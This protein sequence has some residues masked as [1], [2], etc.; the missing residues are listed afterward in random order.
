MI[1]FDKVRER[2]MVYVQTIRLNGILVF[3]FND[4]YSE[5]WVLLEG[6]RIFV[7]IQQF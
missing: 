4:D 3:V 6:K 5:F 7:F 2:K 1:L